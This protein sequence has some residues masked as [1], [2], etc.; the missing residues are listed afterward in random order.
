MQEQHTVK[1]ITRIH[2]NKCVRA[3]N[4]GGPKGGAQLSP[5]NGLPAMAG[6]TDM[7]PCPIFLP[8]N[9]PTSPSQQGIFGEY[10]TTVSEGL[11]KRRVRNRPLLWSLCVPP[12]TGEQRVQGQMPCSMATRGKAAPSCSTLQVPMCRM[13]TAAHAGQTHHRCHWSSLPQ[14]QCGHRVPLPDHLQATLSVTA[15][16]VIADPSAPTVVADQPR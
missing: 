12:D 14:S 2:H 16:P 13:R 4:H 5:A 3:T 8:G 1:D 10:S 9:G 7:M 15:E 11:E 6:P